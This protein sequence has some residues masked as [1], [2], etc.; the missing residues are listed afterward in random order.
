VLVPDAGARPSQ[1]IDVRDLASWLVRAAEDD[2]GGVFNAV[3]PEVPVG[4]HLATAQRVA[5]FTGAVV[6]APEA[7]LAEH[8]VVE[9]AGPRSLPLWL[10]D[11]EWQGFSARDGAKARAA[12]LTHRPLADTLHDVLAWEGSQHTHPHGAGL[13]DDEERDLLRLVAGA[14]TPEP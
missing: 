12:G 8:G 3:G 5:G 4:E 13:T 7:W 6:A 1:L 9:W 11:P 10:A 14:P 2:L